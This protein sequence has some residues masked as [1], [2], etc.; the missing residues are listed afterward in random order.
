[1]TKIIKLFRHNDALMPNVLAWSYV[2]FTYIFGFMAILANDL[3]INAIGVIFLAHSMVIAAYFIHECAHESVFKQSRHN[4]ILGEILLWITGNS[5]SDYKA[6]KKKHVRHHMDRAD[7]VS[8]DFR[9][10]LSEYPK[11]LKLLQTLEWFYIPALEIMMHALVIVLPFIKSNRK[12][13]RSRVA[14][15]LALRITMF[16]LLASISLKVLVLYPIAYMIFLTV[17]RF[18]DVHQHTYDLYETLDQERGEEVKKYDGAFEIA[19]TYSNL[20]SER[21]AWL[22]LF[23]LNFSYHNVHH[24]QQMQPWYALPKLHDKLYKGNETRV[25]TFSKLLKSYHTYRVARIINADEPYTNVHHG[26]DF[27]GVDGV[28]FLTAH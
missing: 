20:I 17:M 16:T 26:K 18:M 14:L 15:V 28:S 9:E 13:L 12:H 10:K 23:V 24:D 27:I 8:F 21:F 6:L 19:N 22:N 11:T 1:M 4:Q 2:L 5:Y 25:L 7:I 3:W